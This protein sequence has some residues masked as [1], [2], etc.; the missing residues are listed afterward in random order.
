MPV[1]R[2]ER[3]VGQLLLELEVPCSFYITDWG[4]EA[5]FG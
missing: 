2:G 4:L 3:W 1:H 5:S